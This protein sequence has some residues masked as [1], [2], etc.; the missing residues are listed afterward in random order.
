MSELIENVAEAIYY[1]EADPENPPRGSWV[2]W[3][4][5]RDQSPDAAAPT[6]RQSH[7][8]IETVFD[9]LI[10]KAIEA[11][12]AYAEQGNDDASDLWLDRVSWLELS[13]ARSLGTEPATGEPGERGT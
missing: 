13:K 3:D 12:D 11:S 1:A 8:A 7:A 9:D 6:V 5:I 4:A 10:T 2:P